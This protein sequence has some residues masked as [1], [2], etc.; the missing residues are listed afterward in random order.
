MM[1][2]MMINKADKVLPQR[3]LIRS[4]EPSTR[5][6]MYFYGL[7]YLNL[8]ESSLCV[9]YDTAIIYVYCLGAMFTTE[10]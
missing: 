6:L 9:K 2:M 8:D 10:V 7:I 4:Q 1:M 5:V 3:L